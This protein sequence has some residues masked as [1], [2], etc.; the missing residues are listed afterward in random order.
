MSATT[1]N[2]L[3]EPEMLT[4]LM[5]V[6]MMR[7]IKFPQKLQIVLPLSSM[8]YRE[9]LKTKVGI[10]RTGGKISSRVKEG[11]QYVGNRIKFQ[12]DVEGPK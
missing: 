3:N 8:F 10:L 1:W 2:T 5:Q 11:D 4:S 9:S 12:R 6:C 7:S